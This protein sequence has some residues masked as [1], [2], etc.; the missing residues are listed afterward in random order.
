ME[1]SDCFNTY[2]KGRRAWLL[3]SAGREGREGSACSLMREFRGLISFSKLRDD[4]KHR[5]LF[6][7]LNKAGPNTFSPG[8]T[9]LW[10]L[11]VCV[12][13]GGDRNLALWHCYILTVR[14]TQRYREC[15]SIEYIE[16]HYPP[17]KFNVS[18]NLQCVLLWIL[19]YMLV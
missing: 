15:E 17:V 11:C 14:L 4:L 10:W 16:Y 2:T 7:Q 12:W 13:G 9:W 5:L 6:A 18:K 3:L 19:Y 1:R 8:F